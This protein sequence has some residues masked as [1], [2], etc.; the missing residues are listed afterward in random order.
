MNCLLV[1]V[2][3]GEPRNVSIPRKPESC[4]SSLPFTL[5]ETEARCVWGTGGGCLGQS[6]IA[7]S[8]ARST[9]L[10]C[11]LRGCQRNTESENEGVKA[12]VRRGYGNLEQGLCL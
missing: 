1:E 10:F 5:E 3:P 2:L 4:N 8:G 7:R 9:P 11:L 6:H 12:G